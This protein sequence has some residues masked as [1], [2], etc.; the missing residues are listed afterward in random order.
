MQT[1]Q[2]I[3]NQA[4]S[5]FFNYKYKN[6]QDAFLTKDLICQKLNIS[7]YELD[8][9]IESYYAGMERDNVFSLAWTNSHQNSYTLPKKQ[10]FI[11]FIVKK[12]HDKHARQQL[13]ENTNFER[14][15][16]V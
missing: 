3:Q 5:L 10:S 1:S 8:R 4:I 15:V 13:K 14:G 16:T 7:I 2:K 6:G 12:E 9:I 11:D